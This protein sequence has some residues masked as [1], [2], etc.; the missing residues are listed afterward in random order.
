ML[1]Q[2]QEEKLDVTTI[3]AEV[4]FVKSQQGRLGKKFKILPKK[5]RDMV[6][7]T[8]LSF[9]SSLDKYLKT[10]LDEPQ[11]NDSTTSR[12]GVDTNSLL[13]MHKLAYSVAGP[14]LYQDHY[15]RRDELNN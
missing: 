8:L 9:K 15:N 7:F 3:F 5:L 12:R 6:N 2:I 10:V 14:L 11:I 4:D 1:Q 13:Y